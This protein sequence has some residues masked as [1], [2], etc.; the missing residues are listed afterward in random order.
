MSRHSRRASTSLHSGAPLRGTGGGR[1]IPAPPTARASAG[2]RGP[3]A[4]LTGSG[5]VLATVTIWSV[6]VIVVKL[7][8]RDSGPLTY[9]ATRFLIG[10]ALLLVVA[11]AMAGGLPRLRRADIRELLIT[12]LIGI[13]ANQTS[14]T[15]ALR[16]TTAVDVSLIMGSIPLAVA[17]HRAVFLHERIGRRGW[18]G[19]AVGAAGLA[20]VVE[21]GGGGHG[22]LGGD[23]LALGAPVTWALYLARLDRLLSRY[24]TLTAGALVTAAGALTL[25]P[26]GA[27]EALADHPSPTP[28]WLGLLAFSAL[29]SSAFGNVAYYRG[30]QLIGAT[31][32]AAFTYLQPFLGAIAA[33]LLLGEE[34]RPTQLLGGGVVVAGI[35]LGGRASASSAVEPEVAVSCVAGEREEVERRPVGAPP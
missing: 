5:L 11:R 31:R 33:R 35:L 23:L 21:A 19:L 3:A 10:G 34:L 1:G 28:S 32:A 27:A 6:N 12:G 20:I 25:L 26:L 30:L 4:G 9:T 17:A 29:L 22:A 2:G 14:F 18:A 7:A 8:L 16:F 13:A 15:V 24:D